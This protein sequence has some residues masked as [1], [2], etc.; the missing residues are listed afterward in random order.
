MVQSDDQ[1]R[2]RAAALAEEVA[3][4]L[5]QGRAAEWLEEVLGSALLDVARQERERCAAVADERVTMW[6]ASLR[7][8]SSGTWPTVAIAEAR[9]RLNE[10]LAL[11]D[12]LRVSIAAPPER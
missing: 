12:A 11:A 10:A 2:A 8:L 4:G 7:R 9:A 1:I 5:H 6:Q 3:A